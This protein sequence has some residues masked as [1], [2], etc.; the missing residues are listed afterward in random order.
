MVTSIRT[1]T[2]RRK[3]SATEQKLSQMSKLEPRMIKE[4]VERILMSEDVQNI[5]S[6]K[7]ISTN[8]EIFY[9]LDEKGV[10]VYSQK[11]KSYLQTIKSFEETSKDPV[12]RDTIKKTDDYVQKLFEKLVPVDLSDSINDR[13]AQVGDGSGIV[14][15][16]WRAARG[17]DI[18]AIMHLGIVSGFASTLSGGFLIR[19]GVQMLGRAQEIGDKEGKD[20]GSIHTSLGLVLFI[21]GLVLVASKIAAL[22]KT[23]VVLSAS[24]IAWY[25]L[26]PLSVLASVSLGGFIYKTANGFRKDFRTILDSKKPEKERVEEATIFLYKSLSVSEEEKAEIREKL[27]PD[28]SLPEGEYKQLEE[29]EIEKVLAVKQARLRRRIGGKAFKAI[30]ENLHDLI[31]NIGSESFDIES[32]KTLIQEVS[33]GNLHQINIGRSCIILALIGLVVTALMFTFGSPVSFFLLLGIT[34]FIWLTLDSSYLSQK[35]FSDLPW[36]LREKIYTK[37]FA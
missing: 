17:S 1:T 7:N 26:F 22:F 30:K 15:N 37:S 14:R 10:S 23:T 12:V 31:K 35:I 11:D 3:I 21:Q 36:Y 4:V 5:L 29:A 33:K 24:T 20:Q 13:I 19:D 32:A 28:E 27:Q 6:S 9:S 16:F 2:H 25:V 18:G 34:S 8:G